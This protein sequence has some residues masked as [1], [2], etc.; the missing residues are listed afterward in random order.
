VPQ[1]IIRKSPIEMFQSYF[2]QH[3]G[4]DWRPDARK[5]GDIVK[6][7]MEEDLGGRI[8]PA[9]LSTRDGREREF[10]RRLSAALVLFL[11]MVGDLRWSIRRAMDHTYRGLRAALDGTDWDPPSGG[12]DIWVPDGAGTA[13][14]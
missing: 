12:P 14:G 6:R 10:D 8:R 9:S 11:Y 5:I 4:R 3:A 1:I 2:A 7:T 13:R